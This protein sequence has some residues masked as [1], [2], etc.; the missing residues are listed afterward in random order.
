LVKQFKANFEPED[1][2]SHQPSDFI[3]SDIPVGI[4]ETLHN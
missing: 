2:E 4:K 3:T 1:P